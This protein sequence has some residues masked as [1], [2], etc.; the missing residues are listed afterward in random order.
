M[1]QE[2]FRE[3]HSQK[4]TPRCALKVNLRKAY[5]SIRWEF[6]LETL[7]IMRFPQKF[8]GWI[9]SCIFSAMF[10]VCINGE[11]VG[12]FK[13]A[14]VLEAVKVSMSGG[15]T[16]DLDSLALLISRW[17]TEVHTFICA[18][19]ELSHT[20]LDV[21]AL[22]QLEISGAHDLIKISLTKEELKIE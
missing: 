7:A 17:S 12:Y 5:D 20:L 3:Y 6:L 16:R 15:F 2:L 10:S 1:A 21:H 8:I 18:W 9:R 19:G 13:G 14:K 4:V 22:L 11:L